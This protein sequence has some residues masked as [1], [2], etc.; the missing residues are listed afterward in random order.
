M[1]KKSKQALT[2]ALTKKELFTHETIKSQKMI[3]AKFASIDTAS[4]K[5]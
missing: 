3:M 5:S 4:L 1:K 2:L